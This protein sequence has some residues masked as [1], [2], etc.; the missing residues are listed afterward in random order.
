MTPEE[1][2]TWPDPGI[3][4]VLLEAGLRAEDEKGC[5]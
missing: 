1:D 4:G 2:E 5:E 3:L